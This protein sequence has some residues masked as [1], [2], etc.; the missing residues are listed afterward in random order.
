MSE[1]LVQAG[2]D[3]ADAVAAEMAELA[4]QLVEAGEKRVRED[5]AAR[6]VATLKEA[7]QPAPPPPPELPPLAE[8]V[9]RESNGLHDVLALL[10]AAEERIDECGA[11]GRIRQDVDYAHDTLRLVQVARERVEAVQEALEPYL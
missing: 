9:H 7:Q 1:K 11:L 2:Q 10:R 6:I 5:V 8:V 3:R 4:R